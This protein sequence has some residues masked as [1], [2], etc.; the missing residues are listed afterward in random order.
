[1]PHPDKI[2]RDILSGCDSHRNQGFLVIPPRGYRLKASLESAM[3]EAYG[4]L[5]HPDIRQISPEGAGNFITVD[6]IRD[7]QAF[8]ASTPGSAEMKTLVLHCAD[9]MNDSAANALLKPLEEP[10][11]HTRLILITDTPASMPAT[12]R[13]RCAVVTVDATEGLARDELIALQSDEE[14]WSEKDVDAALAAADMNP[15][16]AGI[17]IRFGLQK[18][19]K[20][21]TK[22]FGT[23]DAT[24]PLPVLTGKTA[25]P[26]ATIAMSL[27]AHLMRASRGEI[28]ITGW[29]PDRAANAAWT[30]IEGL[31]DI[32]RTGIDAKT[33]LHTL[34]IKARSTSAAAAA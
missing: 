18:W 19:L 13:S 5:V 11:R 31:A 10:T 30:I 23:T 6:K 20:A 24:P 1:M 33:R 7:A 14:M 15:A 29:D 8:L 34:L 32:E 27:Q 22:W 26:L 4:T 12:I 9:R 2:F 21:L 3:V 17:I 16:L 28:D 25:A